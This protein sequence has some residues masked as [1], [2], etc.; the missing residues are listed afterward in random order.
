MIKD[1]LQSQRHALNQWVTKWVCVPQLST[2]WRIRYF[3]IWFWDKMCHQLLFQNSSDLL[4]ND[5]ALN[6]CIPLEHSHFKGAGLMQ[7]TFL[8][9][10]NDI[11]MRS[12]LKS[13][14]LSTIPVWYPVCP[15]DSRRRSHEVHDTLKPDASGLGSD[16]LWQNALMHFQA[17]HLKITRVVKF[18]FW[19]NTQTGEETN[20]FSHK[21]FPF[22]N[23]EL[24]KQSIWKMHSR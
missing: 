10:R 19:N 21:F 14:P 9:Y 5:G 2:C 1:S 3:N 22:V 18:V 16:S 15:L 8:S 13:L 20:V 24:D 17:W 23:D 6:I 12:K 7:C 4:P 11:H